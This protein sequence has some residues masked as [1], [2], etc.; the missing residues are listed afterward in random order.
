[1]KLQCIGEELFAWFVDTLQNIKGRLPSSLLV[2]QANVIGHDLESINQ[3]KIEMG[4][5]PPH[6]SVELPELDFNWLKRWRRLYGVTPRMANL[7]FKAPRQT[8]L[9]V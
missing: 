4:I 8:T 7:R 6:K 5:I 1:M 9:H 2:Q 3:Q